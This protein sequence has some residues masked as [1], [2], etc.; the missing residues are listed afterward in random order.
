MAAG[1]ATVALATMIASISLAP[2][3]AG[4]DEPT[5]P[6]LAL[7]IGVVPQR[8]YDTSD[9]RRMTAAGIGSVRAWVSWAQVEAERGT[10]DWSLVD[11][12]VDTNARAGLTTLPFLF[13][14]PTWAASLDGWSCAPEA[15]S[16]LAPRT[17]A[18]RQAF[19]EFAAAAARRYGPG[20][21]FWRQQPGLDAEPIGTWQIWNE[22]NLSSFW[23]PAV[24]PAGYAALVQAAA[25]AIRAEDPGAQILLAGLTGTKSN[26]KRVSSARFLA[27]LYAVPDIELAFDGIA[28]HPYNRKVQGTLD[29]VRTARA[30]A[31]AQ[32]HDVGLWVTEL[33]WASAGKRRW[34][35][36]KSP[37]GQ[38]RLLGHAL[39]RVTRNAERWNIRGLYW[40]AWRDTDRGAG[41]CG[42]CPWSGLIDRA[43]REKPAYTALREFTE[44]DAR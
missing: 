34:G 1:R 40:F 5:N 41:V 10:F 21:A 39:E 36:V 26:T 18:S 29:Q 4:G 14:T 37:S 3:R 20:G 38:A 11:E 42:W 32:G 23:G 28:V 6:A 44:T 16:R 17:D 31:D 15:C 9:T 2:A 35:L 19:A 30:I 12:I 13:G 24:D 8:G 27:E 25:P 33:G 7:T 43:G 22:P